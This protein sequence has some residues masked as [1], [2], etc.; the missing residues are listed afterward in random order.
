MEL[1]VRL[2]AVFMVLIGGVLFLKPRMAA[3]LTGGPVK[4]TLWD[5]PGP[6]RVVFLRVFGLMFST[7][8]LWISISGS[9]PFEY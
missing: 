8:W 5:N 1:K 4:G 3:N 9:S 2:M 6:I 7:F